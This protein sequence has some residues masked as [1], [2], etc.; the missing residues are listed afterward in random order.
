MSG[1]KGGFSVGIGLV[2]DASAG[3]DALNKRLRALSAP[4]ERFN[5]SMKTFGEVSGI[6]RVAEGVKGLGDNALES[7]R[8]LERMVTPMGLLTSGASIAGVLALTKTWSDAGSAIGRASYALNVPVERLSNLSLA[9]KYAGVSTG[10]LEDS[11][12]TLSKVTQDVAFGQAGEKVQ[13]L[14][15]EFHL[16][17]G[18]REHVTGTADVLGQLAKAMSDPALNTPAK[19]THFLE[20]LGI[21]PEMMVFLVKFQESLD[22]VKKSGGAT[23]A[24]MAAKGDALR[25]S[26]DLLGNAFTSVS[27]RI[28][29]DYSPAVQR[30]VDAT[31]AWVEANPKLSKSI[32]E[33]GVAS[34]ALFALPAFTKLLRLLGYGALIPSAITVGA[35][36]TLGAALGLVGPM[37]GEDPAFSEAKNAEYLRNRGPRALAGPRTPSGSLGPAEPGVPYAGG[38]I[39]N[40]MGITSGQYGG[41]R[42]GVARIEN[43]RYDQMGGSSMRFAGRYQMGDA[44][45]GETARRL[46]V[47]KPTRDQFLNDPAMQER[48]FEAYTAGHDQQLMANSPEYRAMS[49][50]ERLRVL[51]YAHNQGAGGA[52][53]WLRTGVAGRDAFH[54]S[55]TAYYDAV[56]QNLRAAPNGVPNIGPTFGQPGHVKVDVHLHGAPPGT[57]AAVTATGP[58]SAAPP[59]VDTSMPHA[60]M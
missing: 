49:P 31:T 3:I 45:I 13:R 16:D 7:A 17:A 20:V 29:Q 46:F 10:V 40:R 32:G 24:D 21:S 56:G 27:N 18:T 2:D 41:F 59:R 38:D 25:K 33:I 43:A 52:T 39:L 37:G 14:F 57:T 15:N 58:V 28:I 30:A 54:T 60:G 19:K 9:A 34:S 48:F 51:G 6:S 1:S 47:P 44:E 55:G 35:G 5:K 50:S 11:L 23:T 42:A 53:E 26:F 12:S 8:A 22:A 4:A 36:A